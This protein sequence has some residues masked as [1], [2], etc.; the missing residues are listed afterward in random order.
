MIHCFRSHCRSIRENSHRY[1]VSAPRFALHTTSLHYLHVDI[2]LPCCIPHPLSSCFTYSTC[3]G[4]AF[5]APLKKQRYLAAGITC[6][7]TLAFQKNS[8]ALKQLFCTCRHL[9]FF[10]LSWHLQPI[11][12][13]PQWAVIGWYFLTFL[14]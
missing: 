3:A 8:I 7:L 1:Q 2:R 9:P 5:E 4:D 6:M 12:K 14:A 13:P 10:S 11:Q